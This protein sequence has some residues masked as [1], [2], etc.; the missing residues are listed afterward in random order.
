MFVVAPHDGVFSVDPG[1]ASCDGNRRTT[2]TGIPLCI[3]GERLG[4]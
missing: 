1:Y 3:R 4:G 2:R